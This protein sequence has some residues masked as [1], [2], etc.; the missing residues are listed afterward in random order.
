MAIVW[1]IC[2][3]DQRL[4][5]CVWKRYICISVSSD[6]QSGKEENRKKRE[7]HFKE[8]I[9]LIFLNRPWTKSVTFW[10]FPPCLILPCSKAQVFTRMSCL[11]CQVISN[12][13]RLNCL[14]PGTGLSAELQNQ[15]SGPPSHSLPA[16]TELQSQH[17]EMIF[18][19]IQ[20]R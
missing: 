11:S 6:E 2:V 18:T 16:G 20:V 14:F 10:K 13:W 5:T 1:G 4:T 3:L 9:K 19:W 17:S 7:G 8:E 12:C 15:S